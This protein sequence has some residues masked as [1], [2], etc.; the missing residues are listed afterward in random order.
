MKWKLTDL[1]N[2]VRKGREVYIYIYVCDN[3]GNTLEV[4][5][6][7]NLPKTKVGDLNVFWCPNC[8]Q[9]ERW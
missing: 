3:C 8:K 9:L 1:K 6:L 2:I 7:E 4:A 5:D